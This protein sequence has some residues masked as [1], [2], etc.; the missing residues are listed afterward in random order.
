MYLPRLRRIADVLNEVKQVDPDTCLTRSMLI[1][2]MKQGVIT[3]SCRALIRKA[4][5]PLQINP[6]T[7]L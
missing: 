3:A 4:T 6:Y 7:H 1:E 5:L 2:L